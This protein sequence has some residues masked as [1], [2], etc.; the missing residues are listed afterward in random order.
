MLE[1]AESEERACFMGTEATVM[2]SQCPSDMVNEIHALRMSILNAITTIGKK[3][4]ESFFKQ[5]ILHMIFCVRENDILNWSRSVL[6]GIGSL[7][8]DIAS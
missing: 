5:V 2:I 3:T 6:N 7:F 4:G 1:N 8:G